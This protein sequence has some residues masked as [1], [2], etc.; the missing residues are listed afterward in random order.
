M[1]TI[2]NKFLASISSRSSSEDLGEKTLAVLPGSVI[3]V[4]RECEHFIGVSVDLP[5]GTT[6]ATLSEAIRIGCTP[7][8]ATLML[9][10]TMLEAGPGPA[11]RRLMGEALDHLKDFGTVLAGCQASTSED[12]MRRF[13][14]EVGGVIEHIEQHSPDLLTVPMNHYGLELRT[15]RGVFCLIDGQNERRNE[16]VVPLV[17][18]TALVD[19][20]ASLKGSP[21]ALAVL[22]LLELQEHAE[23]SRDLNELIGETTTRLAADISRRALKRLTLKLAQPEGSWA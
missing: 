10:H 9:V 11:R 23:W 13:Q 2:L 18:G 20:A 3:L 7:L 4:D 15:E 1:N 5:T 14:N 17:D 12:Y 22:A 8:E 19:I 16:H 6:A 21:L